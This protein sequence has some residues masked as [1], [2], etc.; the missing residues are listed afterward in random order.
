MRFFP[1]VFVVACAPELAVEATAVESEQ[2][3]VAEPCDACSFEQE[4]EAAPPG[5]AEYYLGF[6]DVDSDMCGGLANSSLGSEM[7]L[8]GEM[9]VDFVQDN[10]LVA[11]KCAY[12]D[13]EAGACKAAEA[14]SFRVTPNAE[15]KV[16]I[17]APV[18]IQVHPEA[19]EQEREIKLSC[20]GVGCASYAAS[21]DIAFP[22]SMVVY[23][24]WK[25]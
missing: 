1:F 12:S 4:E 8:I 16:A 2:G 10:G 6:R 13:R 18:F 9:E 5:V 17:E 21:L 3:Y 7:A 25:K 14:P 20:V 11:L 22:C 23:E 24:G 19:F 15:I